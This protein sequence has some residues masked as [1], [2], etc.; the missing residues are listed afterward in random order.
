TGKQHLAIYL[1]P[2][3]RTAPLRECLRTDSQV[4]HVSR[5]GFLKEDG[6]ADSRRGPFRLLI[7]DSKGRERVEEADVVLDCT[8]T[9]GQHRWMG[10]GGIPAV[11]EMAARPRI[12]HGLEDILGDRRTEYAGKRILLV[13]SGYSAATTACNLAQLGEEHLETWAIWLGRGSGSQPIK[14]IANDPLRE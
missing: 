3:A 11:G 13:G 7:H 4:L 2:L 5:R 12:D 8:G 1:E 10:D 6:T 14:R 9:Y